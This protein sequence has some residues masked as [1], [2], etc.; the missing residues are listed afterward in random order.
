MNKPA[1]PQTEQNGQ[2]MYQASDG[3]WYPTSSM[4]QNWQGPQGGPQGGYGQ[5]QNYYGQQQQMYPQSQP[6][7]VQNRP[8]RAGAG[9]A[10]G[11]GIF[12]ALCGALLCFDLGACLC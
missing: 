6:V 1:Y 8:G 2:Q 3:R 5:P 9:A 10:A 12:A 4:P 11:T 7:Y